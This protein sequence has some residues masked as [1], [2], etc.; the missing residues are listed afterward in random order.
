MIIVL[1]IRN[2]LWPKKSPKG[3]ALIKRR[4]KAFLE[5]NLLLAPQRGPG[6]FLRRFILNAKRVTASYW[7]GLFHCYDD[8][9]IPHT[10]NAIE[11]TFGKGKRLLRACGGRKST[12]VGPGSAGG[13]FF[14]F[15]VAFHSTTSRVERDALLMQ[16]SKE[17]YRAA[18]IK[19]AAIR[20][21]EAKRRQFARSPD[22]VLDRIAENWDRTT[23]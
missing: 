17:E 22:A 15:T 10:S 11:H 12:A 5:N 20:R 13:S 4:L 14:L 19:Q 16:Y 9:R 21:P 8:P 6:T 23:I 18:R 7:P 1:G 3:G 2:I